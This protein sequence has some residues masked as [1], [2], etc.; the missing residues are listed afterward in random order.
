MPPMSQLTLSFFA[1]FQVMLAQRPI[2]HF[3]SANNQ[4]LLVYLALNSDKPLPR[5][6]LATLFWPEE[7]EQT[8]HNNLR[9]ALHQLR[10][11]LADLA[12][13]DTPYLLVTRQSVQWNRD[14]DYGLDVAHFLQAMEKGDLETAVSHYTGDL[15][16]GFSCDSAEFEAWL[17]QEREHLHQLA[18]E[19]MFELTQTHLQNGRLDKA[20]TVARKQLS[21]EPWREQAHRQLMQT[22]ALAG[23][24]GNALAQYERCRQTLWDELGI[25][26]TA[27]TTTLF[28]EIQTG[29]YGPAVS[30]D[31]LRP[32]HKT[33]HNLPA[34]TTPLIGREV[35]IDQIS[36]RLNQPEQRLVTI[37]GPGGMG[38]T[39]L[40]LAVAA[41]LLPRYPEGVYF[42]DLAPLTEPTEIPLAIAAVLGYQAPDKS[43]ELFPQLLKMLSH[44]KMLLVLDNF[45]QLLTGAA[46]VNE[47]LQTCPAVSLLV[48]S[49]QRLNLASESRYE[50]GGLEFPAHPTLED[51]RHFTAVQLFVDNGRRVQPNFSVIPTNVADIC[52]IC[53]LMQGTPLALVLAAAWL[54]LLTPAEI[55]AEI[56]KGLDFL[57]ADLADLPLR[58]RSMQAIFECSWQLMTPAEQ[59]VLAKLSVFRGGFT[60]EA[61][62]QVAGANLRLLLALVNKSLLQRQLEN[63]RFSMHELLRQFAAAKRR[64]ND[65]QG[66]VD[67]AHSRYF[68]A[69]VKTGIR[70]S[71]SFYPMLMPIQHAADRDNLRRAW[72]YVLAQKLPEALPYL[73]RGM[74]LFALRQGIQPFVLAKQAIQSLQALGFSEEDETMLHLR[75]TALI[76]RMGVD[77][78]HVLK[79]WFLTFTP[80]LPKDKPSELHFWLFSMMA[81]LS[82]DLHE[83]EAINFDQE[84]YQVAVQMG[85]NELAQM[86]AAARLWHMV[87][88]GVQQAD[89]QANL[90][91]MLP[92][93]AQNYPE[94]YITYGVLWA[95][96]LCSTRN[97]EHEQ[98]IEYGRRSAS[99]AKQWQD[100][101]WI[102]HSNQV[103]TMA[104]MQRGLWREACLPLLDVLEWHLSIGQVW[105]TLGFLWNMGACYEQLLGGR[106]SAVAILSMVFHHPESPPFYRQQIGEIT[107]QLK[108]ELGEGVFAAAWEKGKGVGFE[109]AVSQVRSALSPD[110]NKR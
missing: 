46:L 110:G 107:P 67:L 60:R 61:A 33:R 92:F 14:S 7:S 12:E 48:T 31:F 9:Q 90:L 84:A 91:A 100:L 42:V 27:E 11:L 66:Q 71:L 101:F 89:T 80:L 63:G 54:E 69:L 58:Q 18:L 30:A 52:R 104:Y 32:P 51:V 22:F 16:P 13:T 85:D 77:D 109:T 70:Q 17:R 19:A 2:T 50:L 45:E 40:A 39:R 57:T 1:T 105:Q 36:Q 106:E 95:L 43:Q 56:E 4:G 82:M 83:T 97:G 6:V 10:K 93:F 78:L 96:S 108:V 62:G 5:E 8:A 29:K 98:A 41:R 88:L 20:Q 28:S 55:A 34:E 68:A 65:P 49:R 74:I 35:E 59:A 25:E 79:E 86:A 103:L 38:K 23:D 53:Q 81:N 99:I 73:T 72:E 87:D 26:P 3:R 94:S 47:M 15:L 24:R 76:S 21:L 64:H 37:V 44:P 75:L 102:T